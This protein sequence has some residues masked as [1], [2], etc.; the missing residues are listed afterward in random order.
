MEVSE[1]IARGRELLYDASSVLLTLGGLWGLRTWSSFP[2][3]VSRIVA[4]RALPLD[5]LLFVLVAEVL[6]SSLALSLYPTFFYASTSS[7][8]SSGGG[9]G[10]PSVSVSGGGVN[11]RATKLPLHRRESTHH[12]K[13]SNKHKI[14]H[15][16]KAVFHYCLC[17]V[18][19]HVFTV[20]FG[21]PL[22]R[23]SLL[24]FQFSIVLVTCTFIPLS[25]VISPTEVLKEV[26]FL[27]LW[28]VSIPSVLR[29]KL[30]LIATIT[31]TMLGTIF[32]PLDWDREWQM[33]P[34]PCVV[35]ALLSHFV[36][37]VISLLYLSLCYVSTD[38]VVRSSNVA[39]TKVKGF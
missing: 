16:L 29:A 6:K 31:G 28:N 3:I 4:E 37:N 9:G 10:G 15:A 12:V 14:S 19:G 35:A 39:H 8:S 36:T 24:T 17:C 32:L 13:L 7:G 26:A 18:V 5:L 22:L 38:K 2:S 21:A 11:N 23:D 27:S 1:G 20:L 33:W 25:L 34:I 30:R